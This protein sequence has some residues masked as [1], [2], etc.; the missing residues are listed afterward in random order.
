[1]FHITEKLY[2]FKHCLAETRTNQ[3][4]NVVVFLD[5]GWICLEADCRTAHLPASALLRSKPARNKPSPLLIARTAM[6]YQT[7]KTDFLCC[8]P[9]TAAARTAMK[10]WIPATPRAPQPSGAANPAFRLSGA[11][12]ASCSHLLN[13][14]TDFIEH[15][16]IFV[17]D[18]SYREA[19]QIKYRVEMTS[20]RVHPLSV[21]GSFGWSGKPKKTVLI[22]KGKQ[23][24]QAMVDCLLRMLFLTFISFNLLNLNPVFNNS[25]PVS[26]LDVLCFLGDYA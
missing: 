19:D 1:M 8:L 10:T 22:C 6:F 4:V 5:T 2:A 17:T 15:R 9:S 13:R 7:T 21:R 26:K 12:N 16:V 11:V 24:R 18:V 25:H 14:E 20:L 3:F 23:R